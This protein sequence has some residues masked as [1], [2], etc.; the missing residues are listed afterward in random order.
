MLEDAGARHLTVRP[1]A[2]EA[3]AGLVAETAAAE[4]GPGLLARI[5]GAAGNPL[6]A[7]ELVEALI[8]EGAVE[9]T[10]DGQRRRS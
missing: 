10:G 8:Q 4:P 7:T 9:T 5:S 2:A 1:L 3:V 6:F